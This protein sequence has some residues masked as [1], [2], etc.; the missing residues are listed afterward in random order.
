M[1]STVMP[2]RRSL[3]HFFSF[4]WLLNFVEGFGVGVPPPYPLGCGT[5]YLCDPNPHNPYSN[6]GYYLRPGWFTMR[7]MYAVDPNYLAS[8]WYQVQNAPQYAQVTERPRW[9]DTQPTNEELAAFFYQ[10]GNGSGGRGQSFK[11]P[12]G[13]HGRQEEHDIYGSDANVIIPYFTSRGSAKH[14]VLIHVHVQH[15]S[16]FYCVVIRPYFVL[17]CPK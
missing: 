11:K 8:Y 17:P 3:K 15:L 16:L 4:I 14:M 5:W 9:E 12:Q 10:K 13:K 2:N 6:V 1:L 7:P